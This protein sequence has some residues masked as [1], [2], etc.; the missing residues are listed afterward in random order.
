M[1]I[2]ALTGSDFM[3]FLG[4]TK[5]KLLNYA[6]AVFYGGDTSLLAL[7]AATKL[8]NTSQFSF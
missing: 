2:H 8:I 3:S 4:Q 6:D 5:L 7:Y 1:F